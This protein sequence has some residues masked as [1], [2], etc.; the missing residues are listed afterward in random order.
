MNKPICQ[1][2]SGGLL[3]VMEGRLCCFLSLNNEHCLWRYCSHHSFQSQPLT[4][5]VLP[6][7]SHKETWFIAGTWGNIC[8]DTQNSTFYPHSSMDMIMNFLNLSPLRWAP[9][10]DQQ[11]LRLVFHDRCGDRH[12]W[13]T[14]VHGAWMWS[15]QILKNAQI[16]RTKW[17]GARQRF[18]TSRAPKGL[19]RWWALQ[20]SSTKTPISVFID[21][22]K[23]IFVPAYVDVLLASFLA[24][25]THCFVGLTAMTTR[26][27][28]TALPLWCPNIFTSLNQASEIHLKQV[29]IFWTTVLSWPVEV[30]MCFSSF[31]QPAQEHPGLLNAR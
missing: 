11:W 29:L 5:R 18:A 23:T 28:I 15:G 25:T 27:P 10:S 13:S 7:V 20:N 30:Q 21:H 22:E 8:I 9:G 31:L 26:Q 16:T 2:F 6:L 17:P 14:P 4:G 1:D 3:A 12:V 19:L 24:V